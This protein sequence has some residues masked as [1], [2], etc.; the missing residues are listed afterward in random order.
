[1]RMEQMELEAQRQHQTH[2]RT[3]SQTPSFGILEPF[4]SGRYK[5]VDSH[6]SQVRTGQVNEKRSF[7]MKSSENLNRRSHEPSPGPRRTRRIGGNDWIRNASQDP[8]ISGGR[9][10]SS[11]GQPIDQGAVRNTVTGWGAELSKSKSSAAVLQPPRVGGSVR[12]KSRERELQQQSQEEKIATYHAL[13][14]VHTNQ[15]HDT[16]D[17]FGKR[18]AEFS[19][20]SGRTT[21]V[22]TCN[23]GEA[24]LENKI[25]A[26]NVEEANTPMG[27]KES[28][29]AT[30]ANTTVPWRTKTPEPALKL[31]NVAVEKQSQSSAPGNSSTNNV[32]YSQNAEAQ[33]AQMAQMAKMA[34]LAS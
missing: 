13:Q 10:G 8:P 17:R 11:L 29:I 7:W 4:E 21:P 16:V 32:R 28:P 33:M 18:Q 12:A 3:R 22:P 9:P 5:K 14:N 1:M 20:S 23:I 19:V 6:F 2:G 30:A 34:K 25:Q 15:V 31:V 26:S 27:H 24:F